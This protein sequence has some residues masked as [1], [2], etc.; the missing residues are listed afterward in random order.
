MHQNIKHHY[1]KTVFSK[2]HFTNMNTFEHIMFE[3]N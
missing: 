3:Y 1:H 2:K